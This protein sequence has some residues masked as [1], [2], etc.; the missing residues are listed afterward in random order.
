MCTA[1][2]SDGPLVCT[3]PTGHPC[4]HVFESTSGVMCAEQKEDA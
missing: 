1:H 4:G 2:L 3:L